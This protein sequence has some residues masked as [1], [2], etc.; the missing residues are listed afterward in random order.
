VSGD[1]PASVSQTPV[2]TLPGVSTAIDEI[3]QDAALV[4]GAISMPARPLAEIIWHLRATVND[5]RTSVRASRSQSVAQGTKNSSPPG[6]TT[7]GDPRRQ[8]PTPG[9]MRVAA[10][11]YTAAQK[12]GAR[13]TPGRSVDVY[14][15]KK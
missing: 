13:R 15:G 8:A 6:S 2:A 10:R 11:A 3:S 14:T 12:L 7:M 4:D 1:L 5:E 9:E